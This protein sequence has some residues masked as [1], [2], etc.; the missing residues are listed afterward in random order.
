MTGN[1]FDTVKVI[2]TSTSL[3]LD[4]E[5]AGVR[6]IWGNENKVFGNY[7]VNQLGKFAFH[8]SLMYKFVEV[9]CLHLFTIKMHILVSISNCK[10]P[11]L[12]KAKASIS[13]FE[14]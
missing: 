13:K 12:T 9:W 5:E 4:P 1:S 7:L 6:R 10:L 14:N 8:N 11:K 2:E 3:S